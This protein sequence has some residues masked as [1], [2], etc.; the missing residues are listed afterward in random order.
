M[1]HDDL[2]KS[3]A[4]LLAWIDGKRNGVNGMLAI[5][6]VI[7]NRSAAG[8]ENGNWVNIVWEELDRKNSIAP[9]TRDPDFQA[10]L[11]HVDGVYSGEIKDNLTTGA[12]HYYDE[13]GDPNLWAIRHDTRYERCAKIG[14]LV[15]LKPENV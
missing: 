7:R 13:M 12:T 8:A 9:D 6:H 4:C 3:M 1:T 14:S 5:L 11:Q 10:I 15:L 2:A